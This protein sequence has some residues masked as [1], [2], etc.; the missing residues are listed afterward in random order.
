ML[1]SALMSCTM[2]A[3]EAQP[4]ELNPSEIATLEDTLSKIDFTAMIYPSHLFVSQDSQ[5][6]TSPRVL[7]TPALK[8]AAIGLAAYFVLSNSENLL[9]R[10]P[11][12]GNFITSICDT[13]TIDATDALTTLGFLC[14]TEG[15]IPLYCDDA[16]NAQRSLINS[17]LAA[18][19][20]QQVIDPKK[21]SPDECSKAFWRA[22]CGVFAYTH[23]NTLLQ[24]QA[25]QNIVEYRK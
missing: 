1:V 4:Q 23:I 18:L 3:D 16:S 21:V 11:F 10:I 7:N 5:D 20:V 12:L 15:I 19:A 2:Q 25:F 8:K 6:S 17:F 24:N 9:L 22:L 13:I 14:A